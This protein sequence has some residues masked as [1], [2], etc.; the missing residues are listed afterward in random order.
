MRPIQAIFGSLAI[1]TMLSVGCSSVQPQASVS[2]TSGVAPSAPVPQT[3][4]QTDAGD[5]SRV[6]SPSPA[7]KPPTPVAQ[8]LGTPLPIEQM[9]IAGIP[10][11]APESAVRQR[12]GEPLSQ[13]DED[14][15][16]CGMVR[17]LGYAPDT[18]IK[19]LESLDGS[20]FEVFSFRTRN[21]DLATRAGIRVGDSHQTLLQT[22]GPPAGIRE[23][24]G[25]TLLFY[26]VP[27]EYA[28]ALW[29][30]LEGDLQSDPSRNRIVEIGYDAQLT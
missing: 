10:L 15:A 13:V 6:T 27:D 5:G 3:E 21:P 29:F 1:A 26:G 22:Y 2:P 16:C 14:W 30:K 24:E 4:P 19:L 7:P 17:T 18:T 23:E 12:F 25:Y 20:T 8:S 9:A 11:Q 28:A